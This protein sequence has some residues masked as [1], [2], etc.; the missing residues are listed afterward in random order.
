MD[1]VQNLLRSLFKIS[2]IAGALLGICG[3]SDLRLPLGNSAPPSPTVNPLPK[4]YR[5][6]PAMPEQP[7][8]Y[9]TVDVRYR[10]VDWKNL[11]SVQNDYSQKGYVPLG[12]CDFREQ[13]GVPLQESA[14][15]YAR[16][17]GADLVLYS[18]QKA[19]NGT[20]TRHH[21]DFFTW[22]RRP[23]GFIAEPT[24]NESALGV[25]FIFD[26]LP[27]ISARRKGISHGGHGGNTEDTEVLRSTGIQVAFPL[28]S[29]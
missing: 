12:Q 10:M 27:R 13:T 8:V 2:L 29:T 20:G 11:T 14:V 18:I 28:A 5:A 6:N 16:Y 7:R 25:S 15:D 3:C 4:H 22:S 19:D 9:G 1:S 26:L 23:G 21:I 17:L 24:L